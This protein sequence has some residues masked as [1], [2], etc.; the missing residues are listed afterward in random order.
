MTEQLMRLTPKELRKLHEG[1][2]ILKKA[3]GLTDA[4]IDAALAYLHGFRSLFDIVKRQQ[5]TLDALAAAVDAHRDGEAR[6]RIEE[7]E[8][9]LKKEPSFIDLSNV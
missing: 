2:S 4:D 5:D 1:V 9:E 7:A 6:K 3:Y 8:E